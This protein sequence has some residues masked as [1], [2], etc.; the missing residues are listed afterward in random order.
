[1]IKTP[2]MLLGLPGLL[3]LI[4]AVSYSQYL[5]VKSLKGLDSL[6]VR[7]ESPNA[8]S[9]GIGITENLLK[10]DLE[11][12]L[13]EAGFTLVD[14]APQA[15]YLNVNLVKSAHSDEFACNIKLELLQGAWLERTDEWNYCSTWYREFLGVY[16][17][18]DIS[19]EI[20]AT[21]SDLMDLFIN[22]ARS[23]NPQNLKK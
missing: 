22:D 15:L 2:S 20:T 23:A 19:A 13:G 1:M 8:D 18:E 12:R 14:D 5:D 21:V 6:S 4:P 10:A 7:I 9:A 17:G 3:C 16:S 11:R